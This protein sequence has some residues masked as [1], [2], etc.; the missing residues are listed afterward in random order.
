MPGVTST[1]PRCRWLMKHSCPR[2]GYPSEDK[3]TEEE[4][5]EDKVRTKEGLEAVGLCREGTNEG[6]D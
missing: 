2:C 4:K 3:R 5:K 1:C 6:W